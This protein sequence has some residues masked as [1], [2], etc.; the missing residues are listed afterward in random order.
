MTTLIGVRFHRTGKLVYCD[1]NNL[2]VMPKD[3]VIV[4]TTSG[5]QIG[6]VVIS[7]DQIVY[8]EVEGP[9]LPVLRKAT[10]QDLL[11]NT[12]DR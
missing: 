9:L 6:W 10:E 3:M 8:S 5:S 7:S 12:L 2:D 1:S 11:V 4:E